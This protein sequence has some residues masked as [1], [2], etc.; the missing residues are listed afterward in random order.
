MST[1]SKST[2]ITTKQPAMTT[3]AAATQPLEPLPEP[4]VTANSPS[5]VTS[6]PMEAAG[7]SD[8]HNPLKPA[9]RHKMTREWV[10]SQRYPRNNVWRQ[11]TARAWTKWID[12][13]YEETLE[14]LKHLP[15]DEA[16]KEAMEAIKPYLCRN[17]RYQA[18]KH[19]KLVQRTHRDPIYKKIMTCYGELLKEDYDT[20]SALRVGIK[21]FEPFIAEAVGL[22][23]V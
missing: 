23:S 7:S 17:I 21:K 20:D 10:K 13:K 2:H 5:F 19:I 14:S 16:K 3:Q 18:W 9:T 15:S 1:Q 11:F 22:H 4:V 8:P 6:D 12:A